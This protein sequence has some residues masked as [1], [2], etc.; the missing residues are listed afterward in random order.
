MQ[1]QLAARGEIADGDW[2]RNFNIQNV[3]PSKPPST[4]Y[5]HAMVGG[6]DHAAVTQKRAGYGSKEVKDVRKSAMTH[7]K[8]SEH[9][10]RIV[11]QQSDVAKGFGVDE[12]EDEGEDDLFFLERPLNTITQRD[13]PPESY[14]K[15]RT[16]TLPDGFSPNNVPPSMRKGNRS[17][18]VSNVFIS[19]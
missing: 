10:M 3:C 19:L 8:A 18:L 17:T 4:A 9:S 6:K 2:A 13:A 7:S 16:T 1:K 15:S 12:D 5:Q 11:C 14:I